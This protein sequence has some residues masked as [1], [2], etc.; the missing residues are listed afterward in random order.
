MNKNYAVL[1]VL[2]MCD[3]WES[4]HAGGG[5]RGTSSSGH[6]D[7]PMQTMVP[8]RR[9]N[10]NRGKRED[11]G[12]AASPN[13]RAS[14]KHRARPRTK[15]KKIPRPPDVAPDIPLDDPFVLKCPHCDSPFCKDNE[16]T[17]NADNGNW[18]DDTLTYSG[19]DHHYRQCAQ[20]S[21]KPPKRQHQRRWNRK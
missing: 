14:R 12:M 18:G 19:E 9:P 4:G 20:R 21:N 2:T 5:G 10:T 11:P 16:C 7:V 6:A 13:A 8:R 15:C 17:K 3:Q 1:F